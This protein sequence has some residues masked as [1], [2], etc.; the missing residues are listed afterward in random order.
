VAESVRS[1]V[2][3]LVAKRG[4]EARVVETI[5]GSAEEA[6]AHRFPGSPTVRVNGRDI[7]PQAEMK[8]DYGFG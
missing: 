4:I 6:A 2:R 1:L 5:V 8:Q 3:N 7:E